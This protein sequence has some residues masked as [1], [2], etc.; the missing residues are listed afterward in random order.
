MPLAAGVT[1]WRIPL[2]DGQGLVYGVDGD[3]VIAGNS[4]PA[5]VAVQRPTTPLSSSA[6]FEA[7]T[8]GMPGEVTS[9]VWLDVEQALAAAGKAGALTGADAKDLAQLRPL[10]SISGWTTGGDTPTFEM[11]ARIAG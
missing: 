1:G 6:D 7:G 11:F 3:L 4:V 8:S 5:V 9:V 10:K 2:G